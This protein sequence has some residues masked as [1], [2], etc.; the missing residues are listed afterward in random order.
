MMH[1]QTNIK[2][3]RTVSGND[4]HGLNDRNRKHAREKR[5]NLKFYFGEFSGQRTDW[6]L[7]LGGVNK[8]K[9]EPQS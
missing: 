6:D 7:C 8:I 3:P 2:S 5:E 9:K 1:V 4:Q